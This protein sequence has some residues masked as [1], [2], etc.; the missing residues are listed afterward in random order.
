[1]M[2]CTVHLFQMEILKLEFVSYNLL[3]MSIYM[4]SEVDCI[5]RLTVHIKENVPIVCFYSWV[6]KGKIFGSQ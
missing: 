5:L 4:E 3:K 6:A 1:M 2:H